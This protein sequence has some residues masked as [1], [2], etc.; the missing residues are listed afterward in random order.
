MP[1]EL[2]EDARL[3]AGYMRESR[4]ISRLLRSGALAAEEEARESAPVPTYAPGTLVIGGGPETLPPHG[5][6]LNYTEQ[7][8]NWLLQMPPAEPPQ[9][10]PGSG[11]QPPRWAAPG[12][13]SSAGVAAALLRQDSSAGAAELLGLLQKSPAG[14]AGDVRGPLPINRDAVC[15]VPRPLPRLLLFRRRRRIF[16]VDRRYPI[17]KLLPAERTVLGPG[18]TGRAGEFVVDVHPAAMLPAVRDAAARPQSGVRVAVWPHSAT[19]ERVAPAPPR[20]SVGIDPVGAPWPRAPHGH[21]FKGATELGWAVSFTAD[22]AAAAGPSQVLPAE[23]ASWVATV[24][25]GWAFEGTAWGCSWAVSAGGCLWEVDA[26]KEAATRA[27]SGGAVAVFCDGNCRGFFHFLL[28]HLPRLALVPDEAWDSDAGTGAIGPLSLAV[29]GLNTS[30]VREYLVDVFGIPPGRLIGLSDA[31]RAWWGDRT[32]EQDTVFAE[33][34]VVPAPQP[35]GGAGTFALARLRRRVFARLGLPGWLPPPRASGRLFEVL[36]CGRGARSKSAAASSQLG[37]R[38]PSNWDEAAAVLRDQ[39]PAERFAVRERERKGAEKQV[40]QW[41]AADI[42][43]GAHGANL[44][45]LIFMRHGAAVVEL[46]PHEYGNLCYYH[47]ASRLGVSHRFVLH[48]GTKTRPYTVDPAELL[49][50]VR[51]AESAAAA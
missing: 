43:I 46:A 21:R 35:C 33:T 32:A 31:K 13:L 22:L 17:R 45:N 26:P 34:L 16:L 19:P 30:F 51:A 39:L 23:S 40:R 3:R 50:H 2:R 25:P 42:A 6:G 48:P 5:V 41:H 37:A 44:A 24:S 14:G 27:P 1:P 47:A 12:R 8:E 7:A 20:V 29:P 15:G 11:W 36:L 10:A 28:E 18:R 49:E 9:P 38:E 4:A